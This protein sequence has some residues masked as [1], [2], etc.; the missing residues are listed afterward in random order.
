MTTQAAHAGK[1]NPGVPALYMALELSDKTWRVLFS[2]PSGKRREVRVPARDFAKLLAEI[3]EAKRRFGMSSE[4]SVVSC[5]EAGRDG[6]KLHRSLRRHGVENNVVD[7]SS[8]EVSRR[9]RHRKT[10]RLDLIKLMEMLQR[11]HGGAGKVWSIVRVPTPEEEDLRRLSR[12]LERLKSE[13]QQHRT[14]IKS[15]LATQGIKL[16]TV[17]GKRWA[18]RVEALRTWD[19]EP[20][21]VHLKQ[22]LELVGQRLAEVQR[23]LSVLKM[24]RDVLMASSHARGA[25]KARLLTQL[26][27][28]AQ[29]SSF[30]FATEV[31]GWRRFENRRQ[32]A[33]SVGIV[34]TPWQSGNIDRDQGISK[35]G[36]RRVRT[37]LVEIALCW[38]RYQPGSALSQWWEGKYRKASGRQRKAGVVALARKLLVSL[39]RY[40][41]EGI[42]PAGAMLKVER[43][44]R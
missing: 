27:G 40:L 10:D 32:L 19:D 20:L 12:S 8:I 24:A 7:S 35:A 1:T 16:V 13:S 41:E 18:E 39:W 4:V 5:Y 11:W 14:R 37:M 28:I 2:I 25:L 31:F 30:V 44:A 42:V 43:G 38:L 9:A 17:G 29:E 36:N 6:F 23:Q 15:L 22:E 21:G 26:C 34:G 3:A 33:A